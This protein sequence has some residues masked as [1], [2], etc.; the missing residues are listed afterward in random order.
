VFA[1]GITIAMLRALGL[2]FLL[3][4]FLYSS[5]LAQTTSGSSSAVLDP[6]S[7]DASVDP[8]VDFYQYS[9]GGWLKNNPIPPDQVSWSVSTKLQD[10]NLAI[11]LNI[12]QNAAAASSRNPVTQKI[13]DYYTACMNDT[14]VENAG[15]T[16]LQPDMERIADMTSKQDIAKVAATMI[17]DDVLF[18]FHS[19][20]DYT[21]SSQIIAEADQ[22]GLSLPDRD[23]YLFK[24]RKSAELR[25]A[26]E[27][28]VRQIFELLGDSPELA[29]AEAH[30][31]LRIE[32]ALAKGSMDR[33]QRR[34]PRKTYHKMTRK[35]FESLCP[36]LEWDRYFAS[37][38]LPALSVLNVA[39]PAFFKAIN[40]LLQKEDLGSW[41]SYM[42]WHL[43]H[44]NAA[45]LP[46]AF[47]NADFDFYGKILQGAKQIAPRWKRCVNSVD[48]NLGEALGQ[49]YVEKVFSPEAK[50]RALH[51]VNQIE[52]AMQQD[53]ETS[54]WMSA[55]TRQHAL[56]KL[57][58]MANKVGYPEK[59]RDY[60]GLTIS[61]DDQLG[62]VLRSRQ[63]EF[64]RQLAK[65]GRSV[66]RGE[67]AM[68]PPT[69]NAYYDEQM[70]DINFPAG[71]L[72]PPLFDSE[73]NTAANYGNTGAT[74]G[75]E[76]THAFDD[77][78]RQF[79]AHGNLIDWWTVQD[80]RQFNQRAA[81]VADQYSRYTVVDHL[82][83][84]G[85]LTLGENV[86]DLG[87]LML[88]YSAWQNEIQGQEPKTQ[89]SNTE[90]GLSPGQQFFLGY[91][92]S[93]C[94]STREQMKRLQ[95][96]ADVHSPEQYR[97][98][99]VVSNMPEFQQ[100][101]HCGAHSPMVRKDRC[102]VW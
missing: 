86:A 102:R 26:Y 7:L 16:P 59:W 74:I 43:V 82:K 15:I 58:A 101:F 73:G 44:A 19:D 32:T 99:G 4:L 38:G 53:I 48:D 39:D 51:M 30:S 27:A 61:R 54:P 87:G 63:F 42:R 49:V 50:Q 35:E 65:I 79:D 23:F 37:V 17:Y 69:V 66:D 56:E 13:G 93:W 68:T 45:Y 1:G 72:Q 71:I 33:M 98:N 52:R 25:R 94:A 40:S 80:A 60:S 90:N 14:A 22:G 67:W 21:D 24:D 92:Q 3:P 47:V 2:L 75:H 12:L 89:D 78:G 83:V 57:H 41:K 20:Q 8:C 76:L 6:S 29:V 84:N 11:L 96:A 88:A 5:A 10:K 55:S 77:E 97:V 91:A 36:S 9:C 70:N 95:S 85:K 62:N 34:D 46:N 18:D 100:A 28:Q 81:C 64:S 31:V